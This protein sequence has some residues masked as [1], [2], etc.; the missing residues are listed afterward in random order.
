MVL[1]CSRACSV[2]HQWQAVQ[3]EVHRL[4][5]T[6]RIVGKFNIISDNTVDMC[7]CKATVTIQDHMDNQGTTTHNIAIS[8]T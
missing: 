1:E 5:R 6:E 4:A 7:K 3:V 2:L 8:S